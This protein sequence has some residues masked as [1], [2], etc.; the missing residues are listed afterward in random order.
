MILLSSFVYSQEQ[1]TVVKRTSGGAFKPIRTQYYDSNTAQWLTMGEWESVY[2]KYNLNSYNVVP[3]ENGFGGLHRKV[4][5]D[6]NFAIAGGSLICASLI[7]YVTGRV[8]VNKMGPQFE[9]RK[10]MIKKNLTY[11]AVSGAGL[12]ALT[13]LLGI[14]VSYEGVPVGNNSYIDTSGAGIKYTKK[15]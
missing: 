14:N 1:Q 8:M 12:G 13:I 9:E 11:V 3:F 15:F 10:K 6:K 5:L 2:G 7:G 4:S